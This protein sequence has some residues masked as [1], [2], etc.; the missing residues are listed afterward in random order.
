MEGGDED[1]EADVTTWHNDKL[2]RMKSDQ[3]MEDKNEPNFE[4]V[5]NQESLPI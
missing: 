2:I 3:F 1:M 4:Q 5:S